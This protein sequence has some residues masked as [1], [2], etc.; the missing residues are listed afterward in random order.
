MLERAQLAA[1][2]GEQAIYEQSI[3]TARGWVEEY[4]DVGTTEAARVRNGLRAAEGVQLAPSLPDISGSLNALNAVMGS[5][6]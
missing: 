4:L 3:R 1:L 5:K 2:R 6:P